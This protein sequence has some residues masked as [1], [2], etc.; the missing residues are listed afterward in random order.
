MT[1]YDWAELLISQITTERYTF[2]QFVDAPNEKIQLQEE[3]VRVRKPDVHYRQYI[4][5]PREV[6][7]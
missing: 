4:T 7:Y 2:G 5:D 1:G 3:L 6:R